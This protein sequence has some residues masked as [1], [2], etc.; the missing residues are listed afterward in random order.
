M[1]CQPSTLEPDHLFVCTSVGAPQAVRLSGLGLIEGAPNEHPGQGTACRRF[2]FNNFY[3][4]L[5]W[6]SDTAEARSEATRRTRL[7]ERWSG[8]NSGACPFGLCFR[9]AQGEHGEPP[10]AN[11]EYRPAYL[12][13][14]LCIQIATNVDALVEPMLCHLSFARR[15]DSY[16][17]ARRQPLDH[18][19]GLREVTRVELATPATKASPE[20]KAIVKANLVQW[21]TGPDYHIQL[22]FDGETLGRNVDCRPALPLSLHW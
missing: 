21:R 22:G 5:L 16:S 9:L 3:V 6:V 10:F 15:P 4:E 7:W 20:L 18:P 12:A 2:F 17:E 14:P 19:A 11:R 8:R 1:Q 13:D